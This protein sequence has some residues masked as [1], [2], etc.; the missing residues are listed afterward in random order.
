MHHYAA[1]PLGLCDFPDVGDRGLI[2][3]CIA[4]VKQLCHLNIERRAGLL[5]NIVYM[6]QN[7]FRPIVIENVRLYVF[8][9]DRSVLIFIVNHIRH[10]PTGLIL[11]S[12]LFQKF[13]TAD[14][15]SGADN[16]G[17][18]SVKGVSHLAAAR[19]NRI[20]CNTAFLLGQ[21]IQFLFCF[22]GIKDTRG[23]FPLRQLRLSAFRLGC[24]F[25]L[26][27]RFF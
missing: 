26:S 17:I 18:L 14:I 25:L 7:I 22:I 20:Q 27:G 5:V 11:A 13:A 24:I 23:L 15:E 2:R 12:Y 8:S 10:I 19:R 9:V 4:I 16:T 3:I 6:G 1:F 21:L